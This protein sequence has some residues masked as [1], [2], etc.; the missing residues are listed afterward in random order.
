MINYK[1]L[2]EKKKIL[3]TLPIKIIMSLYKKPAQIPGCIRSKYTGIN[4]GQGRDIVRYMNRNKI[5]KSLL[6]VL[7][8]LAVVFQSGCADPEQET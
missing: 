6:V 8:S 5:K 4:G 2:N 1:K 7:A 3:A